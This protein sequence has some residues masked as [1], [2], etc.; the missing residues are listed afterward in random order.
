MKKRSLKLCFI[1]VAFVAS[2]FFMSACNNQIG[3]VVFNETQIAMATNQEIEIKDFVTV[4]NISLNDVKFESSDNDIVVVSPRQTLI[5]GEKEG[6]A[7]LKANGYDGFIEIKVFGTSVSFSAPTNIHFNETTSSLEWDNVYAGKIIANNFKIIITKNNEPLQEKIVNSTS[8]KITE[9]GEYKIKVLSMARAG[10]KQSQESEEYTFTKL[11]APKNVKYDAVNNQVTWEGD[12]TSFVVKKNGVLSEK[13]VSKSYSLDLSEEKCYSISVL[14]V[15]DNSSDNVFGSYS[16]TLNLTRLNS[17][18]LQT[19][20]GNI[21]W[22]DEQKGVTYYNIE[23]FKVNNTNETLIKEQKIY[24]NGAD[25]T[26]NVQGILE[27]DYKVKISAIGDNE[28]NGIFDTSKY[29]LNSN[30]SDTGEIYKLKKQTIQFDKATKKIL[31]TDFDITNNYNLSLQIKLNGEVLKEENISNSGEFAFNFENAGIYSFTLI[32]KA[33]NNKQLNSDVSNEIVVEQLPKMQNLTQRVTDENKYQISGIVLENAK[34][35][36]VEKIYNNISTTLTNDNGEYGLVSD[37][38]ASAGDY[39]IVVTASGEDKDNYYVLD[40]KTILNVKKLK[41]VTLKDNGTQIAWENP[42]STLQNIIYKYEITGENQLNGTTK[43]LNFDYSYLPAGFYSIKVCTTHINDS[44]DVLYIN[45]MSCE[46][47]DFENY[48]KIETINAKIDTENNEYVLNITPV[49]NANKYIVLLGGDKITEEEH[50]SSSNLIIPITKCL[51]LAGTGENNLEYKFEIYAINTINPYNTQSDSLKL[52]AKK[53]TAPTNFNVSKD[54]IVSVEH[55]DVAIK[56][57]Q[58]L[59]NDEQTNNLKTNIQDVYN[60]KVKFISNLTNYNNTYYLDSDYAEFTLKR[61]KAEISLKGT[62]VSWHFDKVSQVNTKYI[63][64]KQGENQL[65]IQIKVEDSF[66]FN[67]SDLINNY[68]FDLIAGVKAYATITL[69][70]FKGDIAG[71]YE[72]GNF[73]SGDEGGL[74]NYYLSGTSSG[75]TIK[76]ADEEIG[77]N[78]AEQDEKINVSFNPKQNANYSLYS[79]DKEI[80]LNPNA[81]LNSSDF[82]VTEGSTTSQFTCSLNENLNDEITAYIFTLN[83]LIPAKQIKV[84]ANETLEIEN[85]TG[86]KEISITNNGQKISSLSGFGNKTIN[87]KVK[88]IASENVNPYTFYLD[89]KESSFE[90]IRL[91]GD[92]NLNVNDNVLS[93]NKDETLGVDY[94]VVI[95]FFNESKEEV[96]KEFAS[97]I[98]SIDL[99]SEEYQNIFK[100]LNGKKSVK[101]QKVVKDFV[102]TTESLNYLTSNYSES[103]LLKIINAPTNIKVTATDE[104]KQDELSISWTQDTSDVSIKEYEVEICHNG[105]TEIITTNGAYSISKDNKLFKEAGEWTL[106]V[107]TIGNNDSINSSYSETKTIVRLESIKNLKMNKEGIISWSKDT[108]ASKYYVSYSFNNSD[109]GVITDNNKYGNDITSTDFFATNLKG[110]FSGDIVIKFY[111][112][113]DA[114]TVLSSYAELKMTRLDVPNFVI[115][116]DRIILENYEIYPQNTEIFVTGKIDGKVVINKKVNIEKDNNNKFV[117]YLPTEF[118]YTDESGNA[119]EI[120]LSTSN[121]LTLS[122]QAQN[123][124]NNYLNSFIAEKSTTVL[125]PLTNLRFVRENDGIHF[126]ATNYNLNSSNWSLMLGQET[127]TGSENVDLLITDEILEKLSSNWTFKVQAIGDIKGQYIN[128][129]IITIS[130]TKLDK[131]TSMKTENGAV[132]WNAITNATD[133]KVGIDGSYKTGY[134]QNLKEYLKESNSGEHLIT[135]RALGNVSDNEISSEIILD[136]VNSVS[137]TVTKLPTLSDLTIE[138]GYFKFTTIDKASKYVVD[139]FENDSFSTILSS[140]NLSKAQYYPNEEINNYFACS[141]LNN[142]LKSYSQLYIKIYVQ[143]DEA[144]FVYSDYATINVG[145]SQQNYIIVSNLNN[146][147]EISLS[148]PK[149]NGS[150]TDYTTTIAEWTRNTEANNGYILKIDDKLQIISDNFF[151]LDSDGSWS[152][153]SHTISFMQLGTSIN[154]SGKAYLTNEFST[155]TKVTKLDNVSISLGQSSDNANEPY[156]QFNSVQS[157]NIYYSYLNNIYFKSL[158]DSSNQIKMEELESGK[159]YDGFGI[160]AINSQDVSIIA[161]N[162][163]LMTAFDKDNNEQIVKLAKVTEP[164]PPT[165]QNGS[166]FWELSDADW[167]KLLFSQK[168]TTPFEADFDSFFAQKIR[169]KFSPKAG[170]SSSSYV[171]IDDFYNFVYISDEQFDRIV[172]IIKENYKGNDLNDIIKNIKSLRYY[173]LLGGFASTRFG[174]DKFASTLPV[175]EYKVSVSLIGSGI[176][177]EDDN[178]IAKFSSNFVEISEKYK[179]VA[180]APNIVANAKDGKYTL[181]FSNVNVNTSYYSSEIAYGLIGVKFNEEYGMDEEVELATTSTAKLN[182]SEEVSFDLTYL[183]ESGILTSDYSKLYVIVKGNDNAFNGKLSNVINVQILD[184]IKAYV[185]EGII[186]WAT[187]E[188]ASK[189]QVTYMADAVEKSVDVKLDGDKQSWLGKELAHNIG[190]SVTIQACGLINANIQ[191]SEKFIISGKNTNIGTITKLPSI[192]NE[193]NGFNIQNGVFTWEKVNN[194]SKYYVYTYYE[195]EEPDP[196][197]YITSDTYFEPITNYPGIC[198]YFIMAIGT[199]KN[200]SLSENSKT[201][202]NSDMSAKT[203]AQRVQSIQSITFEDGIIK[204]VPNYSTGRYKLTFYKLDNFSKRGDKNIYYIDNTA[205]DTNNKE[206]LKA[207][208]YYDVEIQALYEEKTEITDVREDGEK[209]YYVISRTNKDENL[210]ST[211]FFKFEQ[212]E[213]IQVKEG[214]IS[215]TYTNLDNIDESDFQFKLVFTVKDRSDLSAVTKKVPSSNYDADAERYYFEDVVF[216][217]IKTT[218]SITVNIFAI[219]TG[220]SNDNFVHSYPVEQTNIHQFETIDESK[221]EISLTDNS[222]LKIDWSKG[223][224]KIDEKSYKY[225]ISFTVGN[226]EYTETTNTEYLIID[227]ISFDYENDYVVVLKIRVIPT[228][229]NYISSAWTSNKEISRPK[230]VTGLKYD[231]EENIFTWDKYTTSTNWKSYRY[232]IKDE[233]TY[234]DANGKEIKEVYIIFAEIGDEKYEPFIIGKH[235]VSVAV[236]VSNTTTDNFISNYNTYEEA[237][238]FALFASGKG[239]ASDP[240]IISNSTQFNNIKYRLSKDVK[241]NE[242]IF[243]TYDTNDNLQLEDQ[244]TIAS[245]NKYFFKLNSHITLTIDGEKNKNDTLNITNA[246][247]NGNFNGDYYTITLNYN[248]IYDTTDFSSISIFNTLGGNAVVENFKLYINITTDEEKGVFYGGAASAYISAICQQNDGTI[249]NINIGETGKTI[250]LKTNDL[251][252][253]FTFVTNK[254]NGTIKDVINNYNVS[255][256]EENTTNDKTIQYASIA[257]YNNGTI[258]NVKNNGN[259]SVTATEIY[260]GGI[261]VSNYSGALIKSAGSKGSITINYQKSGKSY[262][263]GIVTYNEGTLSYCYSTNTFAVSSNSTMQETNIGG[264]IGYSQGGK[265]ENSYV[266]VSLG[267]T[268]GIQLYQVIGKLTAAEGF[269]ENVYYNENLSNPYANG[270]VSTGFKTYT[271]LLQDATGLFGSNTLFNQT[272]AE[273][274]NPR[275][276]FE[277]TFENIIW[278]K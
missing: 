93:W 115:S 207:Y 180:S 226:L 179:Y 28:N 12:G 129:K 3:K 183:I 235:T 264:L 14:S 43:N 248:H 35:V 34:M 159:T 143:T 230:I 116:N 219:A 102:A 124:G 236:M 83:R 237:V 49:A 175:G 106:R 214:K 212:V 130:G 140:F 244:K 59:I 19:N 23:L 165:F 72:N 200:E 135:V 222:Y 202:V 241:N 273:N 189:Y 121:T 181:T 46:S 112:V 233:V 136:S 245:A 109:S 141:E 174:F 231:A 91:G 251:N 123:G 253:Y 262:V 90:F 263:G 247:F 197:L 157:A 76:F 82:D 58:I 139:V 156:I 63:Q 146:A 67:Y 113:G 199:E 265:I 173:Y 234:T 118:S 50:S 81:V 69:D 26:Y 195:R 257:I 88:Y 25:Y 8:I 66:D 193:I 134:N 22:H 190:Y 105:Q 215:W 224:N 84:L 252:V 176:T 229:D 243:G 95:K 52:T 162:I 186:Y 255:I 60:V 71:K 142:K 96:I 158:T 73:V 275:L 182:N 164:N 225:E 167:I 122:L 228:E 269:A 33:K 87:V 1:F 32:N 177:Q 221:I 44:A 104:I 37:I 15:G 57:T 18:I 211:N 160:R 246:T 208:G 187:Q 103:L 240:Y 13:I 68:K 55:S 80:G 274:G 138:N 110:D 163:T 114:T 56:E 78:V 266:N 149:T 204:F 147:S 2:A 53:L 201:Y 259:I 206:E 86:A 107:K 218:D 169:V 217:N 170:T 267:A 188:Y 9:S 77:L 272:D 150:Q 89:S 74:S 20:G 126:K 155:S 191:N 168:I 11:P 92:V 198:H 127:I 24:Y 137:Y 64:I 133:Y 36:T 277:S 153:G 210:A 99:T 4:E 70:N 209:V 151:T 271:N 31:V 194:A 51:N 216:D 242:Y 260:V 184:P 47:I 7:I 249:S 17:P 41:S 154:S 268:S 94:T 27:G 227:N 203:Y 256:I 128:S 261:A 6:T 75:L 161:G 101:L 220:N 5:S 270:T 98:T 213:N 97:S 16:E 117:W 131:V 10:I 172:K 239:T 250:T 111:A 30:K 145:S 54:E 148:N 196:D 40:S 132:V 254:N 38:F 39:Q 85:Q 120:D 108:Q 48:K 238:E 79:R 278:K 61:A 29:F 100:T 171:Y 119:C 178:I 45:N 276:N 152:V 223:I 21:T 205:F 125:S 166:L 232:K 62:K 42:E 185:K 65:T 144:N 192:Y 258:E